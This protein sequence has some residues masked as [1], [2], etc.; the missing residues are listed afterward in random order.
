LIDN[1]KSRLHAYNIVLKHE[2]TAL[3]LKLVR[4]EYFNKNKLSS[5]ERNRSMA[6]SNETVR[7][8]RALDECISK[9]LNK[10]INKLPL[11]VL[12]ILRLG[13]Y[14]YVMDDLVPP[15]AA[16]NSWVELSKKFNNKKISGLINAVLRK[17]KY[18][19]KDTFINRKNLGSRF[20]FQDW[21]I[22]N[23]L[24][25]YGRSKTINLCKY[26]NHK[27]EI[28]LRL[29]TNSE[30]IKNLLKDKKIEWSFSPF[31]KN[32]IRIK[33]GL[34]NILFSNIYSKGHIFVQD[35]AA[36]AVV[37]ALD[38]L[39]GDTVLD[40][41]A[42]PGT[43][44]IYIYEKMKGEGKLFSCD[45]N[46][47]KIDNAVKQTKQL[48]MDID[49][50]RMDASTDNYPM[51]DK[52]LIDA[53]CT[54][55]GVIAR[56]PDIKWR[57]NSSDIEKFTLLQKKIINNVSRFLKKGGVIVY[58]T[59]SLEDQENWN[60]V[61]SFLKFN[62]DFKLESVERKIPEQ[63]LNSNKCLETF[64]PRDNVDGMF[65]AKIKKC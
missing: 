45:I 8:K 53:P 5:N 24:K 48:G 16:V 4:Q 59:C 64:P 23:W 25:K 12:C 43:K 14:E 61:R 60:V 6:L 30:E 41:C 47:S 11:N 39:P 2:S 49:W 34:R 42:A 13:Y 37:E 1:D 17:A 57:R 7:W 54:G 46:Q 29:D 26:L 33:S 50:K 56:K 65:A 3:Q 15:H 62:P 38:P 51:A 22:E 31:S 55:T 18:V 20:S 36:G 44:S 40:V 27:H 10:P 58:A 35:R 19:N 28:D 21:M 52:I 32:Y 9:S 63:W